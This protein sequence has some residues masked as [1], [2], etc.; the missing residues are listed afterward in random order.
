MPDN[1]YKG[2]FDH[3]AAKQT[4]ED[5]MGMLE[6]VGSK[7]PTGV[8]KRF[9]ECNLSRNDKLALGHMIMLAMKAA[10]N[11]HAKPN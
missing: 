6:R 2:M 7:D 11:T 3:D 1:Q 4:D 8:I 5:V 9:L 10:I